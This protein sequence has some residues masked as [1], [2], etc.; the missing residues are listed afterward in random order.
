MLECLAYS[1]GEMKNRKLKD[2]IPQGSQYNSMVKTFQKGFEKSIINEQ[3]PYFLYENRNEILKF[4]SQYYYKNQSISINNENW[5][6]IKKIDFENDNLTKEFI[7]TKNDNFKDYDK[8]IIIPASEIV[9][10]R[11]KK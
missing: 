3:K 2:C 5:E 1:Y 6:K 11:I 9:I 7:E 8:Y 10:A 4:Y